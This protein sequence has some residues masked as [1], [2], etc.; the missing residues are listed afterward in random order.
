M[1]HPTLGTAPTNW[2][3]SLAATDFN[4]DNADATE[5]AQKQFF[6]IGSIGEPEIVTTTLNDFREYVLTKIYTLT[7][8]I[9][10]I[11]SDT[12]D[13]MRKLECGVVI[14]YVLFTTVGQEIGGKDGGICPKS[15]QPSLI[16]DEGNDAIKKW[17]LVIT[18]ESKTAPDMFD[19]PL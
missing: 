4:I 11:G 17:Q 2:G 5:V 12:Y 15:I 8:T 18:W 14:P 10:D 13:F 16:L 9:F 3:S 6:G 7:F 1:W 19:N